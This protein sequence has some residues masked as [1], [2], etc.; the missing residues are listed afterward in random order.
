[1]QR[2]HEL[3]QIADSLLTNKPRAAIMLLEQLWTLTRETK[4]FLYYEGMVCGRLGFIFQHLK[5]YETAIAMHS[6]DIEVSA[7]LG[8]MLGRIKAMANTSLC[9]SSRSSHALGLHYIKICV[10]LS[11]KYG[12]EEDL[13]IIFGVMGDNFLQLNKIDDAIRCLVN[14]YKLSK[15][16]ND[17]KNAQICCQ[18]LGSIHILMNRLEEALTYY[19]SYMNHCNKDTLPGQMCQCQYDI[20]LTLLRLK[21]YDEALPAL[22]ESISNRLHVKRQIRIKRRRSICKCAILLEC[23]AKARTACMETLSE[24][25][26]HKQRYGSSTSMTADEYQIYSWKILA[27]NKLGLYIES[28]FTYECLQ[29]QILSATMDS[30]TFNKKYTC[31]SEER[32]TVEA[33]RDINTPILLYFAVAGDKEIPL[34]FLAY[35]I[36]TQKKSLK[37]SG[38]QIFGIGLNLEELGVFNLHDWV[39]S[40]RET[41]FCEELNASCYQLSHKSNRSR[42]RSTSDTGSHKQ[43]IH[44]QDKSR[45]FSTS[46]SILTSFGSKDSF[47]YLFYFVFIL[48]FN[49]FWTFLTTIRAYI[50]LDFF[51]ASQ[52][53]HNADTCQDCKDA[54]ASCNKNRYPLVLGV[55]ASHADDRYSHSSALPYLRHKYSVP[56]RESVETSLSRNK[57]STSRHIF[58]LLIQPFDRELSGLQDDQKILIICN[59]TVAWIPFSCML[60]ESNIYF[61]TRFKVSQMSSIRITWHLLIQGTPIVRS[62]PFAAATRHILEKAFLYCPIREKSTWDS[63]TTQTAIVKIVCSHL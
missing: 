32:A 18:R 60:D 31:F 5:Q 23:Y 1:M 62:Q 33:I 13:H 55:T 30:N 46:T 16:R 44:K 19:V 51:E 45:A 59:G 36:P 63:S 38:V 6:R 15:K 7:V 14:A 49:L 57:H 48:L 28:I 4:E 56:V 3:F 39:E 52:P 2:F 17:Y 41:L 53:R 34:Q 12:I 9:V 50:L 35:Y 27:E 11:F 24:I 8:D 25:N 42:G 21:R 29:Y 43:S 58:D 26:K 22:E 10:M 20:G 61:S 37:S 54:I 47:F 40:I